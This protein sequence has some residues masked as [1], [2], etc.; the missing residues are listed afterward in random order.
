[1]RTVLAIA[2]I[3]LALVAQ[4]ASADALKGAP[5]VIDGDTIEL[6]GE[7]V[8]FQGIDAPESAQSCRDFHGSEY[9]CGLDATD[10]LKAL[11]FDGP[12]TCEIEPERDRYGRALG[13]CYADDGTDLSGWLVRHGLALAYR[14]Y[15]DLYIV[16]EEQARA[17]RLGLHGGD[18]V[19]PWDWRKGARLPK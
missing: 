19:P 14:R 12:V 2:A 15:S 6:A 8:R 18:Y 10:A 11:I 17:D 5:R 7:R 4:P 3:C 1:M 9:L 13:V 16:A